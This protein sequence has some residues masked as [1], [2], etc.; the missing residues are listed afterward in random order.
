[1]FLRQQ[2]ELF[3]EIHSA[4]MVF[5]IHN[6]LPDGGHLRLVTR[7][8]VPRCVSPG[9]VGRG[10]AGTSKYE[11]DRPFGALVPSCRPCP[12]SGIKVSNRVRV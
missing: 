12:G 4:V 7:G 5:L 10:F 11:L 3:R 9:V 2:L 1:M 6:I 8:P